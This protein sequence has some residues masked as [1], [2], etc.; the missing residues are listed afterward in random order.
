MKSRVGTLAVLVTAIALALAAGAAQAAPV[1][2]NVRIEGNTKTIFEGP[3][4]TTAHPVTGDSTGPHTCDGTNGGAHP[5]AGP[6]ATGAL[7]DA[8]KLAGFTWAGSFDNSFQDFIVNRVGSDSANSSQFWGYAVNGQQ[9]Q[10]GGCQFLVSAGQEVL[11]AF[12]LF[13]K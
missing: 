6:T 8:A 13:S 10:V 5:T 4:S 2:V 3:V 9:P 7:D 12:D 1:Q 11:W